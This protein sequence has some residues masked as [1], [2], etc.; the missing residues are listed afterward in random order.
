RKLSKYFI[1]GFLMRK[2]LSNEVKVSKKKVGEVVN[3]E[4]LSKSGKMRELFNMGF[5]VKE[6]SNLLGVRY[7][8]VYNVISNY[9]NVNEIKVVNETK[10]TKKE[11]IVALY[12]E[13]K[14]R[15]ENS[16][17]LKPNYNDVFSVINEYAGN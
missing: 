8:F 12:E 14:T 1:G 16:S 15:K 9:V 13:G 7:N 17:E 5:S 6:I 11:L 10:V 4:N 3:N 2:Y